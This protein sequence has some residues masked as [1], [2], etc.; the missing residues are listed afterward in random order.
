MC[1]YEI[2]STDSHLEVAPDAW[3]PYVDSEFR[4]FTPQVV[5]LAN[6]GDA[7]LMP[8][9]DSPV[10]LGLNFSA[11][12]GFEN[13]KVSG[14]SYADG[15]VGAGDGE[16]R[17]REMDEDGVD[18][19]VLFPAVAGQRTLDTGA[20]PAEA[21]VAVELDVPITAH[22]SFGGC[23]AAEGAARQ[24][25]AA[26]T[27]ESLMNFAPI[28]AMLSKVASHGFVANQLI[29]S[30]VFDRVPG[31]QFFFAET[32]VGWIPEFME[33]ADE[34]YSRH[35]FW[36]GLDLPHAPSWYVRNHFSWG[37][38]IDRF[39]L[40]VRGDI[41]VDRMQWSTDFPHVQC[42]WPNSRKVIDEQFSGLPDGDRR[43]ILRDNAIRYF[44]LDRG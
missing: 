30:G 31:L 10:P 11:G 13:L 8:G 3:R 23:A 34:N 19:E 9:N 33:D 12:R 26:E 7:W 27:G 16:Q 15:L 32:Q 6:G 37:F 18:A 35:R 42:D 20:L 41:G 17:L 5:K 21:Y 36:S 25:E 40:K 22:V 4:R 2:I 43:M 44:R 38:Q 29:T 39:G 14:I 1:E 28:N 24:R